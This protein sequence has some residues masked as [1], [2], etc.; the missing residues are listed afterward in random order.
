MMRIHSLL[1]NNRFPN[2]QRLAREFEVSPKTV[3]RDIDFM[4][5]QLELPIA[6]DSLRH[7][8][9]YTGAVHRF[10]ALNVSEGELVALLVAQKAVA[11]YK[12]TP[13]E[14][15][16]ERAFQKLTFS[17]PLET[18]VS[19]RDLG[20]AYSFQPAA[21]AE[22]DLRTFETLSGALLARQEVEFHYRALNSRAAEVRC[23]Q[24]CHLR[25]VDN[26]WYLFAY[27]PGRKA[28][29][30]FALPRMARVKNLRR[31]FEPPPGFSLDEMTRFSFGAF[32]SRKAV[33]VCIRL[34]EIGAR[35]LGERRVHPSQKLKTLRGGGAELSMS[36]GLAPDLEAWLLSL[37]HHAEV[38]SPPELRATL[39]DRVFATAAKY[40]H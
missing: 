29:R 32:E 39:A 10:P 2:C 25:C 12:D 13:F 3:Q 5:G 27:D 6:Y 9:M 30:T 7:G 36:V 38:L 23:V 37:G 28:M 40:R 8:F 15:P 21:P 34:D 4:R 35:L 19:L 26:V 17:L 33:R 14:R 18:S 24:P 20:E 31:K 1:E 16:L 22:A 11:Q